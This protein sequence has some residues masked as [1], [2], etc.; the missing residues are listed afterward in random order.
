MLLKFHHKQRNLGKRKIL[1]VK[2]HIKT[3]KRNGILL[4]NQKI[5]KSGGKNTAEI[6]KTGVTTPTGTEYSKIHKAGMVMA[7]AVAALN[8]KAVYFHA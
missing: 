7:V 1:T 4:G 8:N 2:R 5:L 6:G 3:G